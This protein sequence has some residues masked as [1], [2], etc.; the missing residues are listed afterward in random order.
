[1]ASS[2]I[3][4][5]ETFLNNPIGY[6]I[7]QDPAPILM[8]QP[9]L[10]SARGW[11]K[12]RFV[13]MLRDT[14]VLNGLV[15]DP[16]SKDSSNTI[17][18]KV[19]PGGY[20][21]M[22]GANSPASLASRPIRIVMFDEIDKFPASAGPEGDPISLAKKRTTTFWNR[23]I[24]MTSTPSIKGASRIEHAFESSDQRFYHV[25]CPQ[26]DT[27]IV[28]KWG[29][30]DADFGIK[31]DKDQPESA[32]YVC[33]EC[34]GV[35]DET[36]K[37]RM[38]TR[39]KWIATA[40]FK[41]TAGFHINEI[42][43]PWVTWPEMVADF[44]EK[45]KL[46]ETLKTFVTHSLAETWEETGDQVEEGPLLARREHY[47]KAPAGVLV[48]T[49][50][51]DIQE[52]R[53]EITYQG[54]GLDME[55]WMLDHIVV[56]GD[57]DHKDTKTALDQQLARTFETEDGVVL[58]VV[59]ACIDSGHKTQAVYDFV[60]RREVRRIFAIKGVSSV[61]HPVIKRPKEKNKKGVTLHNVGVDQAK[62]LIYGHLKVVDP[63]PG[64]CHF[65]FTGLQT[66]GEIGEEYFQGLTA[67]KCVT[68]F[69]RG[70]PKRVWKQV[71]KRNEPLDCRVYSYAAFYNLNANMEALASH[72]QAMVENPDQ[73]VQKPAR[74]RRRV[75][76]KGVE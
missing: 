28:L 38:L 27:L 47:A 41:K 62:E 2:Q 24:A 16:R 53:V 30:P 21:F 65:P 73:P 17:L 35:V 11:S 70:Y 5:T 69:K 44:L 68:E 63:G 7:H 36:D 20:I 45:K 50:G 54:F 60:K 18:Q 56:P 8:V 25:P 19:F 57:F 22:A 32:Y 33:Q 52:D 6:Y 13:P 26:C 46:P 55:T 48:I 39:G 12:E 1:M 4:K 43:S 14:P 64:Y 42:Y 58:T 29:G 76:S 61:G 15:R 59:S 37:P 49:A 75:I 34:G 72:R 51:V 9:I 74:H 31:W 10:D 67:E 23:K 3:G 66:G 40:P 71:R